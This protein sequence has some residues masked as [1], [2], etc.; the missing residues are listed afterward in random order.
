MII[1]SYITKLNQIN[2]K[3]QSS[4]NT[5][6]SPLA[7]LP[8]KGIFTENIELIVKKTVIDAIYGTWILSSMKIMYSNS[9]TADMY[10]ANP[11]G[12]AIFN[13]DGYLSAQMGSS[14]R[15]NFEIDQ[16]NQGTSEEISSAYKNY[17]AFF[18][19]Y[20]E[21]SPGNLIINIEGCL[22]PNWQGKQIIRFA[23]I[24]DNHLFLTTPQTKLGTNTVI[25]KSVWK[26]A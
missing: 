25:I 16:I 2:H 13:S 14:T 10:G 24:V 4:T 19:H 6:F 11:I 5:L 15:P 21:H 3:H 12:V 22:F 17:M 20:S 1:I 7:L 26:K 23:E 8:K 9:T 18:G